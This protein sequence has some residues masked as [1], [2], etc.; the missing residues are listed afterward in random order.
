M[1]PY[2]LAPGD[3]LINTKRAPMW[4]VVIRTNTRTSGLEV[5]L[6]DNSTDWYP[7]TENYYKSWENT[8]KATYEQVVALRLQG[9]I[10]AE[11]Y[12]IYMKYHK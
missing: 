11:A 10:A 2:P 5:A 4:I 8:V 7:I 3:I 6:A 1:L 9:M 12:E